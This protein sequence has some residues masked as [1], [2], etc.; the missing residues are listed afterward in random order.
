MLN[1]VMKEMPE[2]GKNIES[3][4]YPKKA[5]MYLVSVK[6]DDKWRCKISIFP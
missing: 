2:K 4:W 5:K 3:Y 6:V 1:H